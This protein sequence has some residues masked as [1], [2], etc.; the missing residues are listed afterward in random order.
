MICQDA[1]LGEKEMWR[2]GEGVQESA[3][4]CERGEKDREKVSIP[5]T[6]VR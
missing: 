4:G 2:R 6:K 5:V 1:E 3:R